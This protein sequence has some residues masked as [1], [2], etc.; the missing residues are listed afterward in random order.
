M[1]VQNWMTSGVISVRPDTSLLKAGKLMRDNRIRRLP[2]VN[3]NNSVIGIISDRDVRDASPSK[4][5]TLDMYELHYLLAEIRARDVMTPGPITIL[6]TE[7]V[8]KAAMTMM[9][10]NIGG[11]PVI[12]EGNGLVGI[13]TGYDVLK[14]LIGITGVRNGGIQIGVEIPNRKGSLR[15]V[16]DLLTSLG[17]RILSILSANVDENTRQV[18]LRIRDLDS[19]DDEAALIEAVRR[20]ARLLYW[21]RNEKSFS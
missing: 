17:A 19:R 5:T 6:G 12:G 14:A 16:F 2:V 3:E 21:T 9:D 20:Q 18:F 10:N 7:T 1:L 4:A 11:L 15:P 13:I 8:E